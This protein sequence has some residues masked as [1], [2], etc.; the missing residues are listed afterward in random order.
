MAD[1]AMKDWPL[2]LIRSEA[3]DTLAMRIYEAQKAWHRLRFDW[4]ALPADEREDYRMQALQI[5]QG[6]VR[7]K[8]MP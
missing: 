1:A 6:D 8:G 3:R 4:S 2:A 5:L 7:W